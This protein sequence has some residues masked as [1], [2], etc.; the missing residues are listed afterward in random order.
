MKSFLYAST[1]ALAAAEA[2]VKLDKTVHL[3]NY[4][5]TIK[6]SMGQEKVH[7]F[8][9]TD[10]SW[11]Y[12]VEN[13]GNEGLTNLVLT[14]GE[15]ENWS[16]TVA[17]LSPGEV[18]FKSRADAIDRSSSENAMVSSNEGAQAVDAAAMVLIADYDPD[19]TTPSGVC[20]F[21]TLDFNTLVPGAYVHDDLWDSNGVKVTAISASSGDGYTP[22]DG[23][24]VAE[25]GAARV[26]DTSKPT[27]AD[28]NDMCDD[29]D[30]DEDLGSPNQSCGGPGVG[31]GGLQGTPYE[32]CTPQ[33]NVLIIQ[34]SD[35]SCP[36]DSGGGGDIIFQFKHPT[37]VE[38][39]SLLDVDDNEK[40]PKILV[41]F[42]DDNG[43]TQET[44]FVTVGTGDN[45][46]Y[47]QPIGLEKVSQVIVRF[48]GSGS[49]ANLLYRFCPEDNF[50]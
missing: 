22:I 33:G 43:E 6:G 41:T 5:C 8:E 45:G 50:A 2:Q 1:L 31:D 34:E 21:Q 25:G 9:G 15:D 38:S 48:D 7:G 3:D 36:D 23:A 39:A 4:D 47:T 19:C 24:H 10:I 35:K 29:D 28:G 18:I 20:P 42:E 27:G 12:R 13:T 14:D 44:E 26:F 40:T 37:E 32:N 49:V 11:C 16:E 30:G 17:S 46:L